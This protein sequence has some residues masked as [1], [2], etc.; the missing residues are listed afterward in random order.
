MK[1]IDMYDILINRYDK[2]CLLCDKNPISR[3]DFC[4]ECEQK[5]F[6]ENADEKKAF[7]DKWIPILDTILKLDDCGWISKDYYQPLGYNKDENLWKTL[8]NGRDIETFVILEK[9]PYQLYTDYGPKP[10]CYSIR[11]MLNSPGYQAFLCFDLERFNIWKK[12]QVI[13]KN[14][15]KSGKWQFPNSVFS[16]YE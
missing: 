10:Y 3:G 15:K 4:Y 14:I 11:Y 1:V 12:R 2:N 6:K 13:I 5:C 7:R 16:N 8:N 9:G